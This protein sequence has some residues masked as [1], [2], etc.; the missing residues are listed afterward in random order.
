M[1]L[2]VNQDTY[3]LPEDSE[4]YLSEVLPASNPLTITW[5]VLTEEERA[6]Y[7]QAALRRIEGL[8]VVGQKAYWWQPLKFPRITRGVPPNFK[9]A[10]HEVKRAQVVWAA[11]IA[12]EELYVKR[13][14]NEACL[15]LGLIR[16]TQTIKQARETPP[17][18]EELMHRW[19]TQWR[20]T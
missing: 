15:A 11:E 9:E 20:R 2:T 16:E 1:T 12:R 3:V 14:N 5:A 17:L 6:Q 10:P 8:N 18:V 19:I 13:R 7:L 4:R